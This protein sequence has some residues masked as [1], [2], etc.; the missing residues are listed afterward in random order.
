MLREATHK[1]RLADTFIILIF[2]MQSHKLA[3]CAALLSFISYV[4]YIPII[5]PFYYRVQSKLGEF[6][7]NRLEI[8]RASSKSIF[9]FNKKL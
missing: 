2:N 1:L 7:F 3:Q 8:L 9:F 4:K 5:L 6:L